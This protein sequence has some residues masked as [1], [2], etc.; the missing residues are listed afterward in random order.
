MM[1]HDRRQGDEGE[2]QGAGGRAGDGQHQARRGEARAVGVL[3][4]DRRP[5]KAREAFAAVPGQELVARIRRTTSA[6]AP[7]MKPAASPAPD[8]HR[9][10]A[11]LAI[12]AIEVAARNTEWPTPAASA[13]C[14]FIEAENLLREGCGRSA[15]G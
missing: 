3:E 6:V 4:R 11:G 7:A 15:M 12:V 2:G 9:D 13:P 10:P 8:R 1:G 14:G 5:A